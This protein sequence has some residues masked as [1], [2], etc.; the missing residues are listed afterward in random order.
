MATGST[1]SASSVSAITGFC[2]FAEAK[3]GDNG[4]AGG[5]PEV[6]VGNSSADAETTGRNWDADP[7]DGVDSG[8]VTVLFSAEAG[9]GTA[10]ISWAVSG[11]DAVPITY[12]GRTYGAVGVVKVRAAVQVGAK[13]TWGSVQVKFYRN[14][15]VTES[16]SPAGGPAVD[17]TAGP[18]GVAEQVLTVTPGFANNTK[19]TVSGSVTFECPQGTVPGATD[20]FAQVFLFASGCAAA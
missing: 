20:L 8:P 1:T 17:T 12:V 9:G 3:Y 6:A 18:S 19:V 4:V 5:T 15:R 2:A 13:V 14:G 11:A 7:S 10:G 16:H